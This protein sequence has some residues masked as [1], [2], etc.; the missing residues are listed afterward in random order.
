MSGAV[1]HS[2]S[3]SILNGREWFLPVVFAGLIVATYLAGVVLGTLT[4]GEPT[5]LPFVSEPILYPGLFVVVPP[6]LAA[7]NTLRGGSVPSSLA[8]GLVPGLTFP[9]LG[10]LATLFGIGNGDAPGWTLSLVFGAIGLVGALV[11]TGVAIGITSVS[12]QIE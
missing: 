8:I 3:S 2:R 6:A 9:L 11:G 10:L 12:N 4:R 1:P 5:L 7:A